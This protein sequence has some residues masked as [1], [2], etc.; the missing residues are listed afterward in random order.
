[1][2]S[3]A[4]TFMKRTNQK[5]SST[6]VVILENKPGGVSRRVVHKEDSLGGQKVTC[7]VS[8]RP[9]LHSCRQLTITDHYSTK[10]KLKQQRNT[11][12]SLIRLIENKQPAPQWAVLMCRS[13]SRLPTMFATSRGGEFADTRAKRSTLEQTGLLGW[14][15][16]TQHDTNQTVFERL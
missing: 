11:L 4:T 15:A 8:G 1:M 3:L 13:P 6:T 2:C 16:L 12:F 14:G 5:N 10:T 9:A 7:F